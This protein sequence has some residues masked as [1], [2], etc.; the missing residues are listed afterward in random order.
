MLGTIDLGLGNN[1]E[2]NEE[3]EPEEIITEETP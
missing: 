1:N 2:T 3:I